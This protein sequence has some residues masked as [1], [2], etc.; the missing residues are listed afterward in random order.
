MNQF[1]GVR[2][3]KEFV[4]SEIAEQAHLEG[5]PLSEIEPKMLYLSEAERTLPDIEDVSEIIHRKCNDQEY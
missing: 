4:I 2:N 1:A 5:V 3:A